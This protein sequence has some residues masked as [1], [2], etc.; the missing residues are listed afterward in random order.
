LL[1]TKLRTFDNVLVRIPNETMVKANISNF[2]RFPIR[3][4]DLQVSVGY[5][6]DLGAVLRLLLEVADANP[7]CLEEPAPLFIAQGFGESAIQYQ[8]SV[9]AKSENWLELR[10][11]M[12]QDI[13]AA[14]D[15]A[16]V[17]FPAP[18]RAVAF[19]GEALPVRIL[20]EEGEG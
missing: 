15:A 14:F 20:S 18:Q 1:S 5:G 11:A 3:R 4:V 12:Q 9:W 6:E 10:N 13:K 2:N 17:V 19:R 16:G 7:L 8:F